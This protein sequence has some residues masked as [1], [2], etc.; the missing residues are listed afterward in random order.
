MTNNNYRF[1]FQCIDYFCVHHYNK[2]RYKILIGS[3]RKGVTLC[4]EK[5]ILFAPKLGHVTHC[6]TLCIVFEFVSDNNN[7][8][9]NFISVSMSLA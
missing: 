6:V 5:Y 7:N 2:I 1:L 8:N 3:L 4:V 9:N